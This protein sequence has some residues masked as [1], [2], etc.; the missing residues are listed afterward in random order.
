MIPAN[1]I[2]TWKWIPITRDIVF[3]FLVDALISFILENEGNDLYHLADVAA[4][5]IAD[6]CDV[7]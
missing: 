4:Y 7:S 2:G 1:N 3:I 6:L 5:K